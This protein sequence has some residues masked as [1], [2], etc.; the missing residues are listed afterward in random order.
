MK[1]IVYLIVCTAIFSSCSKKDDNST[2]N[3]T[4]PA[5]AACFTIDR[6]TAIVDPSSNYVFVFTN[7]SQ[8]AG[9]YEWDFGDTTY[10]P[11]ANPIHVYHHSG[12]FVVRMTAYNTDDI[13]ST[14][15]DTILIGTQYYT[16][17]KV[18]FRQS[19]MRFMTPFT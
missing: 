8:N 16:L 2:P 6:D 19:T 18:I 15:L 9:R 14:A 10:A 5:P 13:A 4:A 1:K 11:V 17:D 3:V 12:Y 7:C